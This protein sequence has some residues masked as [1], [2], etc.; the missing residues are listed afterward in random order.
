MKSSDPG[1]ETALFRFGVVS[2][3]LGKRLTGAT[4]SAAVGEAAKCA[5]ARGEKRPCKVSPR[6]IYRWLREYERRGIEGLFDQPR[7]RTVN[8]AVLSPA[9][10]DYLA[11]EK[12]KDPQASIPEVI[13]RAV[14]DGVLPSTKSVNRVTVYRCAKRMNLP[15]FKRRELGRRDMRRFARR[16]RMRST[17]ADGKHFRAGQ[18]RLRR[19]AIIFLDDAHRQ[20]LYGVVG[21][22]ESRQLFLRGLFEVILRYGKMGMLYMDHGSG[23]T[24]KDVSLICARLGIALVHGEVGYPQGRGKIE[25]FNDTLNNDLLRGLDGNP[26]IDPSPKAL[27]Q[28]LNHY[29]T[30]DYNRRH[31][32]GIKGIPEE[33]FRADTVPLEHVPEDV[34]RG[35]FIIHE[36]R[37]VSNDNIVSVDSVAYEMPLGHAGTYVIVRRHLLDG[38]ISVMH[39]GRAITLAEVDLH[40][41]AKTP[42]GRR[43]VEKK[44]ENLPPVTAAMK[45]FSKDYRPLIGSDGGLLKP[46]KEDK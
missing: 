27:E 13:R 45:R 39:E 18:A 7:R 5:H 4:L 43:G 3:V 37:R 1:L 46:K 25:K 22:A 8:S 14:I 6:T 40:A 10:V 29:L 11:K 34:L 26:A 41:N 16:H 15:I 42:R 17:L 44:T 38:K 31:H 19:V 21:T 9:L 30:E 33:H 35:H 20:A 12:M 36:S 24:A 32:E 28:R 2:T 23:F